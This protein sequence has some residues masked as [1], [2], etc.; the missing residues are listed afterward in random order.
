MNTAHSI[1]TRSLAALA[2][3]LALCFAGVSAKPAMADQSQWV[4]KQPNSW[5][6]SNGWHRQWH[7]QRDN[8]FQ[9]CAG[10]CGSGAVFDNGGAVFVSPGVVTGGPN[11]LVNQGHFIVNQGHFI[12]GQPGFVVRRPNIIF[13]RPEFAAKQIAFFR[14]H[15]SLQLG[16][17]M[18]PR[19]WHHQHWNNGMHH[20][21]MHMTMPGM[22]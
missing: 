3:A 5:D 14:R 19:H 15:P 22:N 17:P 21:G 4:R 16:Q 12:V 8:G 10:N 1:V 7:S 18:R 2:V 9:G 6:Q 11:M 13:E 20:G